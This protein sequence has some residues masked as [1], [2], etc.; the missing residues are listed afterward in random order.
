MTFSGEMRFVAAIR[1][2]DDGVSERSV[3]D[4]AAGGIGVR[5]DDDLSSGESLGSVS[6]FDYWDPSTA[7][8]R[9]LEGA[10]MDTMKVKVNGDFQEFE[11]SGTGAGICWTA[12]ASRAAKAG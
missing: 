10:A 12:R 11:F 2:H 3:H 5:D 6:I 1:E 7:V 4:T 8:Q 9:I